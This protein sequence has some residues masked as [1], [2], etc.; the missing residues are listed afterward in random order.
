MVDV[1]AH[2]LHITC[3]GAG[4][5]TVVLE[6][7]FGETSAMWGWVAP[8]LARTT[9]VCAY[10][11]AGRGLS[12]S[13]AGPQ[14]GVALATDLHTLLQRSGVN[15][16][17]VMVG[18]S[19]GALYVLNFAKLFPAQVAGMV[20]LDGTSPYMMTKSPGYSSLYA[21]SR[22]AFALFPSLARLGI[23]RV[24][25][26]G[27][28]ASLP[29]ESRAQSTAYA[30]TAQMARSQIDEWTEGATAMQQAQLL[31]TFGDKPLI[32]V[33]AMREIGAGWLT[34]QNDL[35]ALSTNSDHPS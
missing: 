1:G 35:A 6:A 29:A 8:E 13:A 4:S 33:T 11:R 7:G 34:L 22:V 26:S 5:P 9:K 28:H 17:Y 15:G 18:H 21:T 19:F 16:P 14:D 24:A 31:T 25:Y 27:Q 23:G 12:E 3:T 10:D 30:P 32:I 2:K 20:L